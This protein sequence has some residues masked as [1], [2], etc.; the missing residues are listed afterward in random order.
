MSF[1]AVQPLSRRKALCML[2]PALL[3]PFLASYGGRLLAA[4]STFRFCASD[5]ASGGGSLVF[6]VIRVI[7]VPVFCFWSC[8]WK[9][10]PRYPRYPRSGFSASG[11]ASGSVFRVLR[12]ICVPERY[13]VLLSLCAFSLLTGITYGAEA[14]AEAQKW[15]F[16]RQRN[17]VGT[18]NFTCYMG[19]L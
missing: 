13:G 9:R 3:P 8:F 10:V 6:R 19:A 7:R 1:Y 12:I 15:R 18:R 16:R 5:G 11:R 14:G 4:F 2:P 17:M